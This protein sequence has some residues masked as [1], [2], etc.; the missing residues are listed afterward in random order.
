MLLMEWT[1]T[2]FGRIV[3]KNILYF[4][5]IVSVVFAPLQIANADQNLRDEWM[6]LWDRCRISV[7]TEQP[8][9]NTDLLL[10][11]V[12]NKVDE[13]EVRYSVKQWQFETGRFIV[14]ETMWEFELSKA[15]K[16]MVTPNPATEPLSEKDVAL[17]VYDFMI[18]RERLIFAGVHE[19][20]DVLSPFP[21]ILAGLGLKETK[22]NGCG[23]ISVI[24][25]Q[26]FPLA[27][28]DPEFNTFFSFSRDQSTFPACAFIPRAHPVH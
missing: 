4:C 3:M 19:Y 11:E 26:A 18:E 10:L 28:Q 9:D 6:D 14:E 27:H 1:N 21:L 8:I 7:E 15:R 22:D 24:V 12:N 23:T 5:T 13:N 25:I 2:L 17:L 16:C 20:R